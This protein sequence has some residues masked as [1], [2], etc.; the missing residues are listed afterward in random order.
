[1]DGTTLTGEIVQVLIGRHP[2]LKTLKEKQDSPDGA[3]LLSSPVAAVRATLEGLEGDRHA[4]MTR[5]ADARTPFYPRGIEI[6]NSRQVSL[7]S[8]E[9]LAELA[10]ALGVPRIDPGW[11][12]A[13]LVTRAIPRLSRV[14]PGTRLFFPGE[15]TLV[16]ADENHPCVF[17]GKA[18]QHHYPAMPHVGARFVKAAQHRRG[19]VAWVER[20]GMISTGDQVRVAL[21]PPVTYE[22]PVAQG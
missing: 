1:M 5:R 3:Y 14:P 10:D 8:E 21:A 20:A 16:I 19:L 11:L 9:E 22:V 12:G 17:P 7:V 2:L 6:R 4:G 18:I 13:N 15:A